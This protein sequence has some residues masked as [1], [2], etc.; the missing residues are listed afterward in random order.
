MHLKGTIRS[1]RDEVLRD[2]LKAQ[3]LPL[4]YTVWT[5]HRISVISM[6]DDCRDGV[7][8]P[9]VTPRIDSY[10]GDTVAVWR[11]Q[12]MHLNGTLRSNR[13]ELRRH[14]LGELR[15]SRRWHITL[16]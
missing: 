11:L 16:L 1:N 7:D 3:R 15:L 10:H 6:V 14:H 9:G 2:H 5:T 8:P 4:R 12:P 13:L